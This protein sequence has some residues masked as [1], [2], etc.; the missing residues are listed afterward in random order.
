MRALLIYYSFTEQARIAAELAAKTLR[1]LG[2][3]TASVSIDFADVHQ[4]LRRPL[5]FSE[6]VRWGNLAEQ[7][8]TLPVVLDDAADMKARF[9]FV[10]LFSNTWKFHPS[11]PVQSFLAMPEAAA[12][13]RDTPFV[14]I[15]VCRGFWR[16]NLRLVRE[17]AEKLGGRFI[18]GSGFGFAGSWL[19]STIQSIRYVAATGAEDRRWGLLPLPAFGLSQRSKTQLRDFVRTLPAAV[20]ASGKSPP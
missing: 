10:I 3:D 5:P 9:D 15:V 20:T 11:V 2:V 4:R 17:A 1:E 6:Q 13:L 16:K 14:V 19:A 12:V 7:R 18:G 8:Q